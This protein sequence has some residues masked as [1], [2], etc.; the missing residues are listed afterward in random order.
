MSI[1][2]VAKLAG[3]SPS[4][5]SRVVNSGNST[6]ASPETQQKIWEAVRQVG[7]VPNQ[8][9]RSLKHPQREAKRSRSIDCVYARVIDQ[10]LDPFFTVLMR[11]AEVEAF[12]SGYNLRYHYSIVDIQRGHANSVDSHAESALVLGRLEPGA[13]KLLRKWYKHIVLVGLN[14]MPGNDIDQV[15]S[16]GY[17]ATCTGVRYLMSLGH[18]KICYLGETT[19]EQRFQGY[20]DTMAESGIEDLRRYVIETPFNPTS[21]YDSANELLSRG[22]DFTAIFCANDMSAVGILKAL[23]EHKLK[24]PQDVSLIGIND[25]ETVRYLDPML[26]TVHIPLE[27]MGRMGVKLLIDRMSGGHTLPVKMEIPN[28][29]VCRESCGPAAKPQ[30]PVHMSVSALGG[31]KTIMERYAKR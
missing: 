6:A 1:K 7:Y 28:A 20:L 10:Y 27:E 13:L 14:S 8:N 16:S 18:T 25:M 29:L 24:V 5:V 26:T 22:L 31:E 30:T 2:E 23:R 9:A 17:E 12:N 21:G 3:V 4:T 11:A 15:I 19:N